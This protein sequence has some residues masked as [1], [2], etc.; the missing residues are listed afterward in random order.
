MNFCVCCSNHFSLEGVMQVMCRVSGLKT[1]DSKNTD[2]T[3]GYD[4]FE[5]V[6]EF[7]T[8]HPCQRLIICEIRNRTI[9]GSQV[10]YRLKRS[11]DYKIFNFEPYVLFTYNTLY[12]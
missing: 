10:Y 2:V 3:I 4:T 8:L 1:L 5:V 9:C 11:C 7:A 6:D 12:V